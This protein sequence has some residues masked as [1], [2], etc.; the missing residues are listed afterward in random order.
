M[1]AEKRQSEDGIREVD[2]SIGGDTIKIKRGRSGLDRVLDRV[3]KPRPKKDSLKDNK[4]LTFPPD[5]LR[6][7][8]AVL[9]EALSLSGENEEVYRAIAEIKAKFSVKGACLEL[10]KA[11]KGKSVDSRRVAEYL[12]HTNNTFQEAGEFGK[13][14][15]DVEEGWISDAD[16][17]LSDN[18]PTED[19]IKDFLHGAS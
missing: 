15:P 3:S 9:P 12:I 14:A 17:A 8:R 13:V 7:L 10:I 4:K 18:W 2:I 6:S 11:N 19:E 5:V 1:T 16:T